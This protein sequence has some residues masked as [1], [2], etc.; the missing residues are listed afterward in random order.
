[1]WPVLMPALLAILHYF[2]FQYISV[3]WSEINRI[4][5]PV[6]QI[7]GGILVLY[8]IDSNLGVA[9]DTSLYAIFMN[10]LKNFPLIKR[11]YTLDVHSATH[12]LTGHPPKIRLG[13]PTNTIEEKIAHLQSQIGWLKEDLD[14]EIG[15]VKKIIQSAEERAN[16]S[17]SEIKQ[18]IGVVE[19]KVTELSIGGLKTQLFGVLLMIYG[20]VVSYYA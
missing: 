3:D 1:M 18:K 6:F 7:V 10:Y 17:I 14:D 8:S 12:K 15:N 4:I 2:G 19:S 20:S 9:K 13:G 16:K 5:P 11:H